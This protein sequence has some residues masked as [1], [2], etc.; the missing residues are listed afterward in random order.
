MAKSTRRLHGTRN[1]IT[2]VPSICVGNY[3]DHEILSGVT[4][5]M[6]DDRS[7]AGV[8]VMGGAPGTRETDL[9]DSLNLVQKVDAVLLSGGSAFGLSV[10]DGVMKFLEESGRGYPAR[11]GVLVPIVPAAILYDLYRGS[12]KGRVNAFHGYM[13]C[14]NIGSDCPN[15]NYGA[16]TGAI[17]GGIKGGL[18]TASEILPNGVS[19]GAIVAVN[20]AG[21]IADPLTGGIFAKYL[22]LGSEFNDLPFLPFAGDFIHPLT[23]KLGQNTIIAVVATDLT[24]SKA[25]C[26]KVAKLAHD[27]IARAVRPSH[28]MFYGDTIF[29]ISTQKQITNNRRGSI[30]S[31]IGYIASDCLSRAIVHAVINAK[32]VSGIQSYWDKFRE[33]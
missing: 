3:T 17:A 28:T 15:G 25:E 19:V 33:V 24:L 8:S 26:T 1:S 20:S 13:A 4:V 14:K 5:V 29:M 9:L 27:G 12:R 6:P 11:E 16:G 10:A 30:V 18:G 22:E 31:L 32:S 23:A 7:I 21:Y 2:D